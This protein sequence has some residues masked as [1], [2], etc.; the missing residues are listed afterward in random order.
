MNA[1]DYVVIY[2]SSIDWDF[3]RQDHQ[4][5]CLELAARGRRA[6]FVENTGARW[7]SPA[8]LRRVRLRVANWLRST[9]APREAVPS[10][11]EVASPLALP[12]AAAPLERWLNH[13]LLRWQLAAGVLR[14]G[15][16]RR[17]LWIGLPTWAAVDLA[18]S[19]APDLIVYYCGDAFA[20]IPNVR[21]S[22]R[23]SE[24]AVIA[25]SDV[26]FANSRELVRHCL[27]LGAIDPIL[28]PIG[29]DLGAS[30]DA[31]DGRLPVPQ[32]LRTL[33]GRL[34][35]Y[36][37]GLNHKVDVALLESVARA[38]PQDTLVILG[39]VEDP[40]FVPR[41]P[42]LVILGERAY[43]DIG[44]YLV[45]FDVCLVP[46]VLNEFT[47]S[48]YPGKLVEYLALSR[49]VVSTPLPEVLP[50]S[51]VVRIAEGS[52]AFVRAV[53]DALDT[54]DTDEARSARIRAVERNAYERIVAEMVA[55]VDQRLAAPPSHGTAR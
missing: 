20:E 29:I 1:D 43:E 49:P 4:F 9:R 32:E 46:Y 24:R 37:G 35:G 14:L 21:Q 18:R 8:D 6:L 50:Y 48:V 15:S 17:V 28:V 41:V 54:P 19:L 44:A 40:R 30:S 47:A 10:R 5:I 45:R 39:S 22:L 7:P 42:N 27:A 23:E 38:F 53:R 36:M 25:R 12:G 16:G 11:I 34:I 3:R 51:S 13:S 52:E 2:L 26:V 33:R 31:R 55:I